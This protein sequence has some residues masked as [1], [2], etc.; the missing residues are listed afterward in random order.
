VSDYTGFEQGMQLDGENCCFLCL[1]NFK[2]IIDLTT[3]DQETNPFT[4]CSSIAISGNTCYFKMG[5]RVTDRS[6]NNNP[7]VKSFTKMFAAAPPSAP[8]PVSPPSSPSI[9]ATEYGAPLHNTEL[10]ACPD[11]FSMNGEFVQNCCATC[12]SNDNCAGFVLFN[13]VCYLKQITI[14]SCGQVTSENR[15]A[16]VRQISPTPSS[17]SSPPILCDGACDVCAP[18]AAGNTFGL[19][20]EGGC[21]YTN[22]IEDV[23]NQLQNGW[24]LYK[25]QDPTSSPPPSL[26]SCSYSFSDYDGNQ[27]QSPIDCIYNYHV[28]ENMNCRDHALKYCMHDFIGT[29]LPP[30][31][32]QLP[33]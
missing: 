28:N 11:L 3:L 19:C 1:T 30:S 5:N 31:P 29:P 26:P 32:P 12:S 33:T 25:G 17:P 10:N 18:N 15:I 22:S 21:F 27:V 23:I 14:Q 4:T 20:K 13:K 7:N 6:L 9:C 8:Y 2:Y 16:Y 24:C